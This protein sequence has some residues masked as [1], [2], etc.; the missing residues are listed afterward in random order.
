[1]LNALGVKATKVRGELGKSLASRQRFDKPLKEA[2]A[3][4]L[5]A[6]P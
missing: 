1:V 6:W 4:S 3:S 2:T 5:E